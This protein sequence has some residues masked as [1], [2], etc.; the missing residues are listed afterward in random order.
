[1][2]VSVCTA[3]LRASLAFAFLRIRS[4]TEAKPTS[5][6][7][8]PDPIALLW[9]APGFLQLLSSGSCLEAVDRKAQR[10]LQQP[11]LRQPVTTLQPASDAASRFLLFYYSHW[12]LT[13][14]NP[15]APTACVQPYIIEPCLLE[16]QHVRTSRYT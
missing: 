13:V 5:V 12:V 10:G 8:P 2:S 4:G 14:T 6:Q 3:R 1:M 7:Q 16:S 9:L 11:A 15:I